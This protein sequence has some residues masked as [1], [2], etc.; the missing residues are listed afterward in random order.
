ME[1]N[2]LKHIA[3]IMDGN[4]RWAKAKGLPR[5]AGH[6]AGAE[7]IRKIAIAAQ[8]QGLEQLTLYAFST[9]NWTRPEDEVSYLMKLPKFFFH[10]YL[11]ELIQNNI[12]IKAIG[13]IDRFPDEARSIIL[14]A[15]NKTKDNTGLVIAL[16]LNY[17]GRREIL[18]A[19]QK[20]AAALTENPSLEEQ[21]EAGFEMFLMTA[22][23]PDV[24]LMIRTSGEQRLSNFLLWQNAYSEFV[25]TEKAWPDFDEAELL[26]SIEIYQQRQRRFGGLTK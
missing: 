11:K 10:T 12:Q 18:L 19:A 8:K 25:F 17:G 3:I 5:T 20:Y 21:G 26:K 14:D 13:E 6:K 15:V 23:M 2:S 4:G 16:C 24:D 9:E 7:N 22:G 1:H